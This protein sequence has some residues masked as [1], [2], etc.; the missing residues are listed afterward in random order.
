[1]KN[2][3]CVIYDSPM[4]GKVSNLLSIDIAHERRGQG[5]FISLAFLVGIIH[6]FLLPSGK[7]PQNLLAFG[8]SGP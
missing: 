5:K 1:M 8:K 6:F 4:Q 7:M 3:Y 2:C